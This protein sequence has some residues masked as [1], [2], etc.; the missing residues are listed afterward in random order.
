MG[1]AREGETGE[2]DDHAAH[3]PRITRAQVATAAIRLV[4]LNAQ[5]TSMQ[6]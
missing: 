1:C 6:G 3:P 5:W 4:A 2:Q